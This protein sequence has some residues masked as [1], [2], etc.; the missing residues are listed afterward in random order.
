MLRGIKKSFGHVEALTGVDL[1]IRAGEVVGLAGD[2]G[3]GKST[4]IKILSGV[5]RPD[6]GELEIDGRPFPFLTPTLAL[7]LGIATV[8]QDLA[9]DNFRDAAANIFLGQEKRRFGIILDRKAMLE[10]ARNLLQDLKISLPSLRSPVRDLSGGQRQAIAVA[11]ALH[12]GRRL[13]IFDEPTAAMGL[14]ESTAVLGL[15]ARLAQRGL[16]VVVICHNIPQLVG[17]AHRIYVMRHGE[18]IRQYADGISLD[19]VQQLLLDG[20]REICHAG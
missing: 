14:K 3:S 18:I 17:I 13:I 11:R 12:R 8:Y 16:A 15:I 7:D 6:A 10:E 5:L 19:D 9:L 4:L 1:E 2:N 20:S